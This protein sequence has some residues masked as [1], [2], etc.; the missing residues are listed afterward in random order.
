MKKQKKL[1]ISAEKLHIQEVRRFARR[2]DK[3]FTSL[4]F[5][6][7][8][9]TNVE[10]VSYRKL[11]IDSLYIYENIWLICE[12]TTSKGDSKIR[13]HINSKLEVFNYIHDNFKEFHQLL[14]EHFPERSNLL[15][16]YD[17]DRIKFYILYIPKNEFLTDDK[18][19][20][21]YQKCFI[22][23]PQVQN[24]FLTLSQRIKVS[25]RN[26][27]FR[28]LDVHLKDICKAS[29]YTNSPVFT[30]PIIYPKSFTGLSNGVRVVSFMM[31]AGKLLNSCY[32][33]RKD[34]WE[35]SIYL[36]QR[37]I[38]KNKIKKIRQFLLKGQT[39]FYNNI[40]ASLPDS[41]KITDDAGNAVPIERIDS[42][43]G[44]YAL[45][46]PEELNSIGIIDG[47]H[48]VFAHYEGGSQSEEMVLKPLRENLHLLVT[49]LV[50]PQNMP[51]DEKIRIQSQ[52]F[53]DINSN[54]KTVP[55][56]V[57]LHIKRLNSPLASESIAQR[58][59]EGLNKVEP[60]KNLLQINEL[61]IGKIKTAS[62]VKFALRY[63]VTITPAEG[64][65]SL[66]NYWSVDKDKIN[67]LTDDELSEYVRYCESVISQYF[68]A[69]KV[70]FKDQWG[71]KN[72]KLLS[73]I[74]INAFLIALSRSI[75]LTEPQPF[76]FYKKIFAKWKYSFIEDF[77]YSSSQYRK[78]STVILSEA[79]K[80]SPEDLQKI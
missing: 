20:I 13:E 77:V 29:S 30:A 7:L 17:V 76:E 37:L 47:Q 16:K 38:D 22:V 1:P 64:K 15:T 68:S 6:S 65:K 50:F 80:L 21:R 55:P 14:C 54:V 46:F 70:A 45:T 74:A 26:E 28:F 78:F 53:L 42:L 12:Q 24:Y 49:G 56:S 36:Y 19:K 33:L 34:N 60:F 69:V 40:I 79:F 3:I 35:D 4:G 32:V 57:L 73:V 10:L 25:A 75:Q 48:R 41:I 39:S 71:V 23:Q 72:S 8:A 18:D 11:E 43:E 66:Y 2:V 44:K 5:K 59:I 27:L 31:P 51:E 62:I 67:N 61:D 63:L 58:V 52:I 9:V